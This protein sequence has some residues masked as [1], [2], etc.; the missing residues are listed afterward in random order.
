[1]WQTDESEQHKPLIEEPH[2]GILKFSTSPLHSEAKSTA[3]KDVRRKVIT[4]G[5][6][7]NSR[8]YWFSMCVLVC[9]VIIFFLIRLK[10]HRHVMLWGSGAKVNHHEYNT[11]SESPQGHITFIEHNNSTVAYLKRL[12]AILK[13][14]VLRLNQIKKRNEREIMRLKRSLTRD[15]DVIDS[16]QTIRKKMN[17]PIVKHLYPYLGPAVAPCVNYLDRAYELE[18]LHLDFFRA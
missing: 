2:P 10:Y 12:I 11:G 16:L 13:V 18:V 6:Y 17:M 3:P 1:M 8:I 5:H 9:F 15:E 14:R 4:C 7:R